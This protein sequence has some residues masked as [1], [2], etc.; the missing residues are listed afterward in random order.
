M[1]NFGAHTKS[2]FLFWSPVHH[3]LCYQFFTHT[4]THVNFVA[5]TSYNIVYHTNYYP[6]H[7]NGSYHTTILW[8]TL[9][10]VLAVKTPPQLLEQLLLLIPG[11]L[12]L[13]QLHAAEGIRQHVVHGAHAVVTVV[14]GRLR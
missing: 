13:G 6:H 3:T 4:H 2:S 12:S 7:N 9:Y 14:T 1:L 8:Y 10:N 5:I 11:S